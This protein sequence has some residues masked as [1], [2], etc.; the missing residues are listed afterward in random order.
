MRRLL[1][2]AIIIG[3]SAVATFGS[4]LW[5][6]AQSVSSAPNV[7]VVLRATEARLRERMQRRGIA[8][9][10]QA[11]TDVIPC[12]VLTRLHARILK[13]EGV[14]S[15]SSAASSSSSRSSRT[16]SSVSSSSSVLSQP[17]NRPL[18]PLLDVQLA[19]SVVALLGETTPIL[20]SVEIFM[21]QEPLDVTAIE[22]TVSGTSTGVD[23]VFVYDDD[24]RLLG[25]AHKSS[26]VY[27]LTL[28]S[29]TFIIDRKTTRSVYVR[30]QMAP[31]E[32]V[33]TSGGV[34]A[35]TGITIE[36]N[37]YWSGEAY[38]KPLTDDFPGAQTA[39]AGFT[40]ISATT[41]SEAS[42]HDG[43]FR[44]LWGARFE[45]RTTDN[46]A[47]LQLQTLVFELSQSD[48]TLSNIVLTDGQSSVACSQSS[49]LITCSGIPADLGTVRDV[50]TLSLH[51]DVSGVSD[52]ANPYLQVV[53][54]DAGTPTSAGDIVWT[55]GTSSF[56]WVTGGSPIARGT[57]FSR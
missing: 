19:T 8:C 26:G 49:D 22:V 2:S 31:Y 28:P 38:I 20:G 57:V 6:H 30:A 42:I 21:S 16:S 53:L 15:P 36:G 11:P 55:D 32:R 51:A 12:A 35:V 3:I 27:R 7:H 40:R 17:S 54:H 24:R 39:R 18:D 5:A 48:S 37:G 23:A 47:Q 1:V 45:G 29:G 52:G 14:S 33:Q 25:T 43:P 46:A 13:L 41:D 9:P 50:R 34:F 4:S 10:P 44:K 56:T